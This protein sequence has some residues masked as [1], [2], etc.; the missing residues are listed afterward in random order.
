[1]P[2]E[3]KDYYRILGVPRYASD[4]EIKKAFRKLDWQYHPSPSLGLF[5]ACRLEFPFMD[6]PRLEQLRKWSWKTPAVVS[7]MPSSTRLG[8]TAVP[9]SGIATRHVAAVQLWQSI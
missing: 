9:R 3:F 7:S 5:K 8:G 6:T 1:M 4:E 2:V